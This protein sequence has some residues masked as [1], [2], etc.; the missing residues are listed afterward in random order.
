MKVFCK[1]A[2]A[3]V[4][5]SSHIERGEPC[6]DYAAST[7]GKTVGA[8]ALADGA[9]SARHSA[10]GARLVVLGTLKLV[11]NEFRELVRMQPEDAAERIVDPLKRALARHAERR[12]ID[13]VAL[14]STLLFAAS[15]GVHFLCGQL[16]DGRVAM[17]DKTSWRAKAAFEPHKG[18][19]FNE[20]VFVTSRN[21]SVDLRFSSGEIGDLGGFAL[22]SD[23]AEE[24]LYNRAAASF[25]PALTSMM[26]WLAGHPERSVRSALGDNLSKTLRERTTDD[27]SV[28]LLRLVPP[29]S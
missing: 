17:F 12:S 13:V 23:G 27:L 28:A 3:A 22:L 19:F 14:A 7:R 29:P 26:G 4:V 25:A 11:R 10:E 9:G 5:G 15:D 20:T 6:Q 18:E 21:A 2:A 24:S 1:M 8:I 16:G